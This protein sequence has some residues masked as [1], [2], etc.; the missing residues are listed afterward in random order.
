MPR[1]VRQQ[2]ASQRLRAKFNIQDWW[3]WLSEEIE[4]R[5]LDEQFG[6]TP[7]GLALNFIFLI[8]QANAGSSSPSSDL[9][10]TGSSPGWA[11]WLVSGKW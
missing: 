9:F 1:L 2:S 5:D 10:D 8:A 7:I 4:T 6:G 11:S 3:L